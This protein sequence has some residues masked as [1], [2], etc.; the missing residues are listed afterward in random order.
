MGVTYSF[1]IDV[2]IVPAD[3]LIETMSILLIEKRDSGRVI[4]VAHKDIQKHTTPNKRRDV[5]MRRAIRKI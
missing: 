5:R 2:E 1:M 3:M 4:F